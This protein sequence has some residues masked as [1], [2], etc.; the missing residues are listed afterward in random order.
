MNFIM[1]SYHS[2]PIVMDIGTAL[3]KIG[4]AGED[5]PNLIVPTFPKSPIG[6]RPSVIRPLKERNEI[7]PLSL[8]QKNFSQGKSPLERGIITDW[9]V[10]ERFLQ[11]VFYNLLR[12]DPTTHPV[13]LSETP[14]NPVEIRNK[15]AHLMFE[16]FGVPSLLIIMQPALSLYASGR[17]TGCIVDIGEGVTKVVPI[18]EGYVLTHAIQLMD[19]AGQDITRYLL[20]LLREAGYP[21]TSSTEKSHAIDIKETF[22]YVS[23]DFNKEKEVMKNSSTMEKIYNTPDGE[24]IK[25]KGERFIAPE[26]L[27]KPILIGKE[28]NSLHEAV[29]EAISLCDK[30]LHRDFYRNIILSGGSSKFPGLKERLKHEITKIVPKSVEVNIV[31]SPQRELLTWI[32]GSILGFL[33]SFSE[34]AITKQQYEKTGY[35]Y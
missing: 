31:A 14:L 29:L 7:G 4:F 15:M 2:R 5:N 6:A 30:N 19:I 20:R 17:T 21:L 9:V 33:P 35:E 16:K 11:S 12:I 22:C 34:I 24:E 10:I 3:S 1:T 26:C 8:I 32:G 18:S 13:I 23:T 27:F 28:I 25:I